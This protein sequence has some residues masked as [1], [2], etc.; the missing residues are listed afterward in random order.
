MPSKKTQEITRQSILALCALWD[1]EG[2][3]NQ[4]IVDHMEAHGESTSLTTLKKIRKSGAENEG[5]NY[6]LTIRP[7]C[8]VFLENAKKPAPP[9]PFKVELLD[10]MEPSKQIQF[11]L[12]QLHEKDKQIAAKD[13]QLYHRAMAMMERWKVV[14]HLSKEV[15]AQKL[16]L[17]AYRLIIAA[18]LVLAAVGFATDKL[19]FIGG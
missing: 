12:D 4:M 1:S 9:E 16:F 7:L 15:D 17:L 13:D 10:G 8:R 6:N 19:I 2:W 5:F 3:T 14:R 18:C 11:L